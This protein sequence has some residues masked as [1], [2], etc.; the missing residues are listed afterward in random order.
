LFDACLQANFS[1]ASKAG[2]HYDLTK[3][4]EGTL[5]NARPELAV[6]LV[7]N[8]DT[9][10]LQ[11]L[12]QTVEPWFRAHAYT[13]TLLREAGYPCVFYADIYGSHY[14]D[15]GTDGKDHEVTLEPLPQLDRLLRLRKEK[16]YGPQ[17]D[18]FDHPSC[19]GWTR[20]GDQEHENSGL[21]IIL[22][23]GE[24]GH[25]AME[26]GVQ[27]AG[28]TFT[29]Q[30]GHAQGEVVINE[31]GWGEFYCEAGSVSVWGVA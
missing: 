14:T 9:Q 22:S 27:F 15:T 2:E 24:A 31:N 17:C 20:E 11:S 10:P 1:N 8:H 21:A 6:T 25:K 28:K 18:Y 7:E 13:I 19:I 3:I 23:N 12:E 26:V 4:L 29:D 30:L 16:A 5:V